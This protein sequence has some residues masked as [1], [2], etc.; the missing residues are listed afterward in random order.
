MK[1]DSY[2][3]FYCTDY[4]REYEESLSPV[5]STSANFG[6]SPTLLKSQ[7][8]CSLDILDGSSRGTGGH[9]FN[10]QDL[11]PTYS[12]GSS[13]PSFKHRL[14]SASAL[15]QTES[16]EELV[17]KIRAAFSLNIKETA[18]VLRVE[19]PTIYAWLSG[20][21]KPHHANILRLQLI[22]R[23]ADKWNSRMHFPM[24]KYVR[25]PFQNYP[26][27]VE[28]LSKE[29]LS[30][31]AI[32]HMFQLIMD[33]IKQDKRLS[34][35]QKAIRTGIDLKNVNEQIEEIDALTGKRSDTE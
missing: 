18:S 9:F 27:T 1:L 29:S 8:L 24:G 22:A 34:L 26:S 21:S 2:Q 33:K 16:P 15:P 13:I 25:F 7:P 17:A 19:R 28:Q 4:L 3:N 35:R 20:E 10:P 11:E 31:E 5:S 32:G 23:L 6:E 30:E 14:R 12:T